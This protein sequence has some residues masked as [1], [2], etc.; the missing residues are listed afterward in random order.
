MAGLMVASALIE[1][2]I[3]SF[4]GKLTMLT[5]VELLLSACLKAANLFAQVE[6]KVTF[7]F[8]K[9]DLESLFLI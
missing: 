9:L 4:C 6:W 7:V 5:K 3:L 8:G 1:S 2:I